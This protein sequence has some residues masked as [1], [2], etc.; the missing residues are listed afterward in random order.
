VT[1]ADE[2][3]TEEQVAEDGLWP[4]TELGGPEQRTSNRHCAIATVLCRIPETDYQKLKEAAR[5]FT[6]FIPLYEEYGIVY[7]FAV[8]H[9]GEGS[10]TGRIGRAYARVLYLSPRLERSARDIVIAVVAH[11][12]A[13]IAVC[14]EYSHP[15]SAEG[16]TQEDI[17]FQRICEWG[18]RREAEKHRA[19]NKRRAH[20]RAFG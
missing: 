2:A 9:G 8:T 7:P 15:D 4:C 12:L 17:V 20:S 13:H 11:E 18:F 1:T 6:W 5:S 10:G 3:R 16:K 19:L 14:E